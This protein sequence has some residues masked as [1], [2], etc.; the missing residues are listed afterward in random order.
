MLNCAANICLSC[1]VFFH[2]VHWQMMLFPVNGEYV[3]IHPYNIAS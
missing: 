1:G 2:V 3:G